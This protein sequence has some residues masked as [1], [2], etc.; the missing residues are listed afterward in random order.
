MIIQRGSAKENKRARLPITTDVNTR[1]SSKSETPSLYS[2]ERGVKR[3]YRPKQD[4]ASSNSENTG[5]RLDR[6]GTWG[7]T[8]LRVENKSQTKD[9]PK[10]QSNIGGK[11]APNQK[12]N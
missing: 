4:P 11:K 5:H 10:E 6:W 1:V 8:Q 12:V 2:E 9:T 7:T 3:N